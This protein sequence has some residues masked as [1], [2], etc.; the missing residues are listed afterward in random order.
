MGNWSCRRKNLFKD[1]HYNVDTVVG[2]AD[3]YGSYVEIISSATYNLAVVP[4]SYGY[5]IGKNDLAIGGPGSEV[6][7]VSGITVGQ[8]NHRYPFPIGF[9]VKGGERVSMRSSAWSTGTKQNGLIAYPESLCPVIV[10]DSVETIGVSASGDN[11]Y[12]V[13]VVSDTSAW[14]QLSDGSHGGAKMIVISYQC[15]SPYYETALSTKISIGIGSSYSSNT[16]IVDYPCGDQAFGPIPIYIPA[17]EAIW[18]Y[19]NGS[20]ESGSPARF[21]AYLIR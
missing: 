11:I 5:S 15:G 14:I 2:S 1:L 18:L 19:R 6:N 4:E 8:D 17:G 7:V 16:P 20:G 10:V 13:P 12:G 9:R 21:A 3:T